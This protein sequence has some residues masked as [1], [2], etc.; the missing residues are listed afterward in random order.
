MPAFAD[1]TLP[2]SKWAQREQVAQVDFQ[3]L[4]G[5]RLTASV[6]NLCQ[7]LTTLTVKIKFVFQQNFLYFKLSPYPLDPS[8]VTEK[9]L[10]PSSLLPTI[11]YF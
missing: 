2:C 9:C 8:L 11:R 6:N 3:H 7:C 1:P 10:A 4:Q 5:Q